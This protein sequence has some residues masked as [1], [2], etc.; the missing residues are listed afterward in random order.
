MTV[1]GE[2]IQEWEDEE[3]RFLGG[4]RTLVTNAI[5]LYGESMSFIY[6]LACSVS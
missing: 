3:L 5:G 1:S 2:L 4:G 6:R